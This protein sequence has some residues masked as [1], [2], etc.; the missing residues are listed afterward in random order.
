[1]ETGSGNLNLTLAGYKV[2]RKASP[3]LLGRLRKHPSATAGSAILSVFIV[4][5]LLAPILPL[6]D[7]LATAPAMARRPPSW[8]H[9]LGT[10]D[11]GRDLLSRVVYGGR[12]SLVLGLVAT[13][14][15]GTV[16]TLLGLAAGFFRGRVDLFLSQLNDILLAFP[17]FLLAM[18]AV[19]VLGTGINN[20]MLAVG[21]SL[22]PT[23][24]RVI[25]SATLTVRELDYVQAARVA[26]A[27]SLR[28]MLRHVLPNVLP[29]AIVLATVT[30]G[31]AILTGAAL[32]FLGLGA[33]PP[34]PEWGLMVNEGRRSLR[35]AWW[36]STF[37]GLAIMLVVI[38]MNLLGDALRDILDPRLRGRW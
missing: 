35:I 24:A 23:F 5:A 32:S 34:V 14:V 36:I 27:T 11:L 2:G 1:M 6:P 12:V 33:Q 26:G 25:R 9:P 28:I 3:T 38:G 16:G 19:A 7:P 22:V 8:E 18:A 30:L 37:P 10:D 4:V 20:V 29:P 15:G 13:A 21:F 17:S 31:S